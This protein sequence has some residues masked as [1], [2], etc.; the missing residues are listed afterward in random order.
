MSLRNGI[1]YLSCGV[2]LALVA[3]G[4]FEKV[5][6]AL[7]VLSE[8]RQE[9]IGD[10]S[11]SLCYVVSTDQ[12]ITFDV[13]SGHG[14]VKIVVNGLC[15]R[16]Q[17]Y[18]N[19]EDI[20]FGLNLR[21]S[22]ADGLAYNREYHF[23]SRLSAKVEAEDGREHDRLFL[24]D[25]S[26]RP[27]DGR[28][29]RLDLGTKDTRKKELHVKLSG[30]DPGVR[31]VLCR[32]YY[33]QP[34]SKAARD[35]EWERLGRSKRERL[36]RGNVYPP[37]LLR[38][39][40]KLLYSRRRWVAIAP[41][42]VV[43]KH[44]RVRTL[45]RRPRSMGTSRIRDDRMGGLVVRPGLHGVVPIPEGRH[46]VE[47]E[48]L[49]TGDSRM[50]ARPVGGVLRWYG[51]GAGDEEERGFRVVAEDLTIRQFVDGG[52]LEFRVD[53]ALSLRVFIL[54][55]EARTEITPGSRVVTCYV[56]R[57]DA[58]VEYRT[59]TVGEKPTPFRIDFRLAGDRFDRSDAS[60]MYELLTEGGEVI[61]R[62]ELIVPFD[63]TPYD[64]ELTAEGPHRAVSS[65]T[66][67]YFSLAPECAR[68]RVYGDERGVLVSAGNRLPGSTRR[69]KVPENQFAFA[70][71]EEKER[72]WFPLAPM[73]K[74][75]LRMEG[76]RRVIS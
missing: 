47:V 33:E 65:R 57:S 68:V 60:A 14:G 55:D 44:Y 4:G 58:S 32:I 76:R 8:S 73:N 17:L 11:H 18:A 22:G 20:R 36:S 64:E 7:S 50:Y 62:G 61:A 48:I 43:G 19:G 5:L 35:F 3:T 1:I 74:L 34:L 53:A 41:R 16:P 54:E 29:A 37:D 38:D 45:Y 26:A 25:T 46:H 10:A 66:R 23:R 28:V 59:R 9:E 6:L 24:L 63:E 71:A 12:W 2:F 31:D 49:R 21:L 42:G 39:E 27:T 52:L 40:E 69:A 70:R 30:A 15:R 75:G 51:N 56:A 67:I 13:P 72:G